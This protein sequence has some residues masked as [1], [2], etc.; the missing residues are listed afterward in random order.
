MAGTRASESDSG[1]QR[2]AGSRRY[3]RASSGRVRVRPIEYGAVVSPKPAGSGYSRYV[4]RV[5]AL[6]VALGIGAAIASMPAVAFADENGSA[7]STGSG[8][9]SAAGGSSP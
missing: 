3:R 2:S 6:A 4:G 7:G 9:S 8:S 1:D 5:G